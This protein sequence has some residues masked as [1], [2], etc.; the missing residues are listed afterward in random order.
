MTNNFPSDINQIREARAFFEGKVSKCLQ[1][2]T[3][4][5]AAWWKSDSVFSQFLSSGNRGQE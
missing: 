1:I 4:G 5:T 3:V 2:K